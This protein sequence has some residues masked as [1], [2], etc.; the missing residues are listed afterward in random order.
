MNQIRSKHSVTAI[1]DRLKKAGKQPVLRV[2]SAEADFQRTEMK[3]I[4]SLKWGGQARAIK[5]HVADLPSEV[6]NLLAE[7]FEQ[8]VIA[9]REKLESEY[10]EIKRESNELAVRNERQLAQIGSL[11]A[12]IGD[13]SAKIEFLTVALINAR[14]KMAERAGLISQL[15]N[16]IAVGREA[17][18]KAEQRIRDARQE[19]TRAEHTLEDHPSDISGGA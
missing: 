11:K 18:I 17:L 14:A 1:A 13:A 5:T 19:L 4:S 3:N 6:Q 12:M 10:A 8:K 15:K 16:E 7:E 9:F 2:V